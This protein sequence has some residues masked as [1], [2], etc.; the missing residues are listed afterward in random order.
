[1]L[2]F[3]EARQRLLDLGRGART[4]GSETVAL[5]QADGRVLARDLVAPEDLPGFDASTMDGYAVDH[6]VLQG[7]RALPGDACGVLPVVG[8]SRAGHAVPA[9]LPG[10]AMRIFTGAELPVGA[11]AVIMQERVERIEDRA[12]FA[13]SATP[14][15]NVRRQGS[16]L[17]AGELALAAGVR[18]G[19]AA[20]GL[21]ASCDH[22]T[23]E[24]FARPRVTIF[25]TGD[26]LL[27]AG[28]PR[29]RGQLPES[30]GAAIAAMARRSGAELL[31]RR[32]LLDDR[33]LV[34]RALDEALASSD[35][36]V[37]I[38]GVSVGDHAVVRDALADAGATLEFW[39]VAIKPGK[40]LAV[41]RRGAALFLGLP[42]NPASAM[43]T[44]ALFG[45][46]LLRTLGG[47]RAP[48]PRGLA[49]VVLH[50]LPHEPGRLELVRASLSLEGGVLGVRAVTHQASGANLGMVRADALLAVPLACTGLRAGD[51]AT[52]YPF[53]ELALQ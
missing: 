28:T 45:A 41:G 24:V 19:P 30:N 5:D 49:A 15:Q 4:P 12:R 3:E 40:P 29:R 27:P 37:T 47:E 11:D 43:V 50:D 2:S 26:E 25:T 34:A 9:L 10:T 7:A 32:T 39:R 21:A 23:L 38:G 14:W 22:A 52:V 48:L 33:A 18:L 53:S 16:D 36:V 42:G 20:L 44:F 51:T 17:R 35:V 8:E 6:A 46:P 1:M 31:V 13:Q